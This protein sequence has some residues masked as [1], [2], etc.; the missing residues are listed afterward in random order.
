MIYSSKPRLR[1]TAQSTAA[2]TEI[3]SK[4]HKEFRHLSVSQEKPA[5]HYAG[6][7]P[8]STFHSFIFF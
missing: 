5:V 4:C 2:A 8:S 7:R 3:A 6:L 1:Q